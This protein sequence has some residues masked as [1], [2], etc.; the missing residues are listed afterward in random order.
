MGRG[1]ALIAVGDFGK[2][3]LEM[4]T[5]GITCSPIPHRRHKYVSFHVRI[6]GWGGNREGQEAEYRKP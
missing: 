6:W 4:R 3:G 5:P 2:E 1:E